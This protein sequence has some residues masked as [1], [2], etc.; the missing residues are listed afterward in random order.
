M[1]SGIYS[2][3][4]II[5]DCFRMCTALVKNP[6]FKTN[7]SRNICKFIFLRKVKAEPTLCKERNPKR[8]LRSDISLS[9]YPSSAEIKSILFLSSVVI[10]RKSAVISSEELLVFFVSRDLDLHSA[11]PKIAVNYAT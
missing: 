2:N 4:R 7:S 1:C 3:R 9:R 10:F 5:T 6:Y 11:V 8:R